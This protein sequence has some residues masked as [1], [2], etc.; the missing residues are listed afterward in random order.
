MLWKE[1][2]QYLELLE[3]A[4]QDCPGLPI[5]LG[6]EC[7]YLERKTDWLEKTLVLAEFDYLI[8]SVHYVSAD[9]AVDDPRY[10]ARWKGVAAVEEIWGEYW[11]LYEQMVRTQLFD[12]HGHPDL[13][14][15]FGFQPQGDL[16]RYYEPTIKALAE[17]NGVFEINTAGLRK[18]CAEMYPTRQF[19]EM[20]FAAG[21]ALVISSDSHAAGEVGM[22]FGKAV[23]LAREVGYRSTVRFKGRN[24][25]EVPLP[26]VW[27][28]EQ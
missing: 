26:E 5:R 23:S 22:G 17:T 4:R 9:W 11:R 3:Q 12:I 14:K 20:A 19:L 1:F 8:G 21:V 18:D 15:K 25:T 13:P 28:S 16:R 24:R 6:L 2:P 7:D 10:L 27:I